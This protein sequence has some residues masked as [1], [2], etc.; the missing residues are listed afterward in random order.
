MRFSLSLRRR[1][2]LPSKVS[3]LGQRLGSHPS[4]S[5]TN[6]PSLSLTFPSHVSEAQV[7][8]S[9][10]RGHLSNNRHS[11]GAFWVPACSGGAAMNKTGTCVT[12]DFRSS[13]SSEGG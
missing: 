1:W 4:P 2:G 7:G 13:H 10:P 6:P 12:L 5:V 11:S 9:R 8:C 3:E